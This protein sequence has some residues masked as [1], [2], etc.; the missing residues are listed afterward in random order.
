MLAPLRFALVVAA[1][2]A[3]G[4]TRPG[5][6]AHYVIRTSDLHAT[7]EFTTRVLGL[8]VLRHEENPEACP[9]TCNGDYAVPWSKTMVGTRAE[10]EAYA[11]EITYNYGVDGYAAARPPP[12]R[13][14]RRRRGG[15][16]G[17]ATALGYSVHGTSVVG[18]DGYAF[19]LRDRPAGRREPFKSVHFE[20][21]DPRAT[22]AWYAKTLGMAAAPHGTG[23]RVYFAA[24][25]AES[26]VFDFHEGDRRPGAAR[27]PQRLLLP[28]ARVRAIYDQL[29]RDE[30]DR[31]VHELQEINEETGLGVLLIAI[32]ADV[33]GLGSPRELRREPAIA[34]AHDGVGPDWAQRAQLAIDYADKVAEAKANKPAG[35]GWAS[36]G[37][38]YDSRPASI[39]RRKRRI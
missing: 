39:R 33:N 4:G 22:A 2:S 36:G 24:D 3:A 15:G 1:A 20:V 31:V 18:P 21:A 25:E 34:G 23:E 29:A 10:D 16:G 9:I 11:L 26:V 13:D 27:R 5:P 30:P 37:K 35:F 14:V 38:R 7:L 8:V 6:A 19:K 17:R 32:V 28:A 12:L